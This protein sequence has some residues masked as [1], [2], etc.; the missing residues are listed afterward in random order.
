MVIKC[1]ANEQKLFLLLPSM[2]TTVISCTITEAVVFTTMLD[3]LLQG[4]LN[5]M[6]NIIIIITGII[7]IPGSHSFLKFLTLHRRNGGLPGKDTGTGQLWS[8]LPL[9]M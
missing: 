4:V 7:L 8:V 9:K 1:H 3:K 6:N 5:V 2:P